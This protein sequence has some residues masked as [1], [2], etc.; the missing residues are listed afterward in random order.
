MGFWLRVVAFMRVPS[1]ESS[2][3]GIEGLRAGRGLVARRRP[4]GE[5]VGRWGWRAWLGSSATIFAICALL[6]VRD[7]GGARSLVR[8]VLVRF[9]ALRVTGR[10]GGAHGRC[11]E[12]VVRRTCVRRVGSSQLGAAPM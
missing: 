10:C 4:A 5:H 11:G 9:V 3:C 7:G 8:L 2:E 12:L 1:G 6:L